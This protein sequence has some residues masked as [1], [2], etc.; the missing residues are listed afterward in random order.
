MIIHEPPSLALTIPAESTVA[1]F[2]SDEVQVTCLFVAAEG[3]TVATS[4]KV[5]PE[6]RPRTVLLSVIP[7]T[8][9]TTVTVHEAVK[10]PLFVLQVITA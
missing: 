10:P 8:P 7:F 1:T 4:S 5:S 3:V 2:S 6:L 9:I